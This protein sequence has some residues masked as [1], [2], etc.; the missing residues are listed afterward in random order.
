MKKSIVSLLLCLCLLFFTGCDEVLSSFLEELEGLDFLTT[1]TTTTNTPGGGDQPP[2]GTPPTEPPEEL[3]SYGYYYDQLSEHAKAVYRAVYA[4]SKKTD[5]ISVSLDE[6]ISFTSAEEDM[7]ALNEAMRT[8]VKQTVQPALDALIFDHPEIFWIAMGSST[9]SVYTRGEDN[10]DGTVT[11][12]ADELTFQLAFEESLATPEE[13]L[14]LETAL[15]EKIATYPKAADNRY[16]TL[17]SLHRKL[18]EEVVYEK[19]ATDAHDGAGALLYGEA[20]CDGYAKA[21][22]MLC[23]A[24][25]I[26][27]IIVV[28]NAV[29]N[30]NEERHAW[31]YVQME[32]GK[33]YAVDATWNDS[34]IYPT[35]NYFLVGSDTLQPSLTGGSFSHSHRPDGKFSSGE[36]TPFTFPVLER[37]RYSIPLFPS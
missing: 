34:G 4:N 18:C 26:P 12:Y 29:Q 13:V 21:F 33:W 35:K 20:V 24:Y 22:K 10:G 3:G 30:G 31:N 2:E 32:D 11:L 7:E 19:D 28:G 37:N 14:M 27:C 8:A 17:L 6:P 16:D 1:V 36:Y 15:L 5:G 23:D 9:F 25:G